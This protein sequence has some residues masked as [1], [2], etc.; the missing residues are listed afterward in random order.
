MDQSYSW[1]NYPRYNATYHDYD[2]AETTSNFRVKS[3]PYGNG[4]SY[5]DSCLSEHLVGFKHHNHFLSFDMQQG[6]L[7]VHSGVRVEEILEVIVPQGW[8]LKVNPGTKLITIGGAIASDVHGKNHHIEGCFSECVNWFT[9]LLP[10][11]EQLTCSRVENQ[12]LFYATCGGM[13]LTGFILDVEIRL[14]KIN[15]THITQHLYKTRDLQETIDYFETIKEIPYSVAWIDT[16]AT[17]KSMGRSLVMSGDFDTDGDLRYHPKTRLTVP[18]YFPS[19]FLN[20][21]TLKL[22]NWFY[23]TR[24]TRKS[25][26]SRVHADAFF[27][28]LDSINHWN[29]IY[30]KQG[31]T[32]YQFILPKAASYEGLSSVL[33]EIS[34][35]GKGSFLSVLKLHGKENDNYLSFPLEGFSLA[36]DFKLEDGVFELLDRLDRIVLTYNGRIYLAKDVRVSKEVFEKGYPNVE[37]FRKIRHT[38]NLNSYLSSF[39]SER[40]GI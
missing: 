12:E 19:F 30:G 28:P 23:Y 17:G 38:Y 1:G 24:V 32:Q 29:R 33:K 16:Q 6:L 10:T 36:L 18:F 4:R 35:S 37:Q 15:S 31:F 11:G 26:V 13:G 40:I 8:F 21:A 9:L 22:F 5:G 7:S 3:I 20:A 34:A 2:P 27:F 39:Q 14:K 25:S